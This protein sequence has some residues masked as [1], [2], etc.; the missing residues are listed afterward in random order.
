MDWNPIQGRES[1]NSL[2][3]K[4]LF[5]A[6]LR[7]LNEQYDFDPTPPG[8]AMQ[9]VNAWLEA[10]CS[11]EPMRRV[12]AILDELESHPPLEEKRREK[13]RQA[14]ESS[15]K[16][17]A[18]WY[19]QTFDGPIQAAEWDRRQR[20]RA[21][22][23]YRWR[24]KRDP[25]KD[26]EDFSPYL[27]KNTEDPSAKEE[28]GESEESEQVSD[29]PSDPQDREEDQDFQPSYTDINSKSEHEPIFLTESEGPE[30]WSSVQPL[31]MPLDADC[32]PE[33][34]ED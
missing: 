20:P 10:A 1:L 3:A 18:C 16:A 30:P 17:L 28:P 32:Y 21:P 26:E 19:E 25:S 29:Y 5:S 34:C 8:W 23:A 11:S 24:P 22:A 31:E 15:L 9:H 13:I 4:E 14:V 6:L 7:D 12:K 27:V 2:T 33:V